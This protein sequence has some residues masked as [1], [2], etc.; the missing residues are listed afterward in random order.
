MQHKQL[1]HDE[2]PSTFDIWRL[3]DGES[4]GWAGDKYVSHGPSI[5][6]IESGVGGWFWEEYD[7]PSNKANER[8]QRIVDAG[9]Y[10]E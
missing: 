9:W 7:N 6:I 10:T 1:K 3:E 4:K 2:Y 8:I 5:V